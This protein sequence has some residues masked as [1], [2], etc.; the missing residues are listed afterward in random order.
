MPK[1]RLS[2]GT[3]GHD[4]L[5][6]AL[7]A[8]QRVQDAHEGHGGREG[9]ALAAALELALEGGE[10]RHLQRLR[11]RPARGQGAAERAAPLAQVVQL[12]AALLEAEEGDLLELLVGQ[13]Q[14]EAVAEL[15]QV[16][17]AHLLLLVGDV[18]ALAGLAHAVALDGLGE[19]DGGLAL[20][21][22]RRV[23]GRV[24]LL[25]VVAAAGQGPD[26]VVRHVGDHGLQLGVLAEEVLAHVGAVLRLEVLVLAVDR[27]LHPAQQDAAA[28][29][30]DQRVPAGAPDGLDDVPAGPAED[31][32]QLLDDLAVA[33][34]RPVEA[35]Q[36]AVDDED[37]VV[38]PLPAAL[39]HGSAV[40]AH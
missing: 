22:R 40:W 24:D 18:L 28:V 4:A 1:V 34:H 23:V 33:A 8:Q 35:L 12:R 29:A 7:V 2:S 11:L 39:L 25:R 31:A 20:V 30:G 15:L 26:L 19:D 13:R 5:A 21:L 9:A 37:Q 3:M 36:V 6:D 38:E 16:G 10:R 32:L 14:A 27:L 17:L